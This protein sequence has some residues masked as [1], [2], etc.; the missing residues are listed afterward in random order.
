[1]KVTSL[2]WDAPLFRV[3]PTPPCWLCGSPRHTIQSVVIGSDR[4]TSPG[5]SATRNFNNGDGAKTLND[6][7]LLACP[8][9]VTTTFPVLAPVGTG[10]TIDVPPH[11]VGV[12]TTPLNVT[13]LE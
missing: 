2:I 8:P 12:A 13:L 3:T 6:I 7:P 4:L 11:V 9:T 1:M 10:T 5:L